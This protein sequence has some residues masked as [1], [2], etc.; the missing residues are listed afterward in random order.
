MEI[1]F[2]KQYCCTYLYSV[3]SCCS[4][5]LGPFRA[6]LSEIN[7]NDEDEDERDEDED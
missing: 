2:T 4:M 3:S 1:K 5:I 7:Q 6:L